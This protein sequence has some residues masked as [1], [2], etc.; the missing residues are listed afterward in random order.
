MIRKKIVLPNISDYMSYITKIL[1]D[2]FSQDVPTSSEVQG[3]PTVAKFLVNK[4]G[5]I[6]T[7]EESGEDNG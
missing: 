5:F 4:E 3:T 2:S 1:I 7:E 6:L